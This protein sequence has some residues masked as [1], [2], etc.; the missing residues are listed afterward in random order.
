MARKGKC[1]NCGRVITLIADDCCG[2]CSKAGEG[3]TGKEKEAALAAIKQKIESGAIK[4]RG[5]GY[6]L[7]HEVP[8]RPVPAPEK[9]PIAVPYGEA[10]VL[11]VPA[12]PPPEIPVTLRL[13]VEVC[14]RVSCSM[15]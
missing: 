1:R 11:K 6:N 5:R 13:T 9:S 10:P 12:A 14:V 7:P 4:P 8:V 2:T 3:F 15:A